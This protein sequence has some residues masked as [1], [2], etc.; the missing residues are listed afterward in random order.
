FEQYDCDY[1]VNSI[2]G[3]GAMLVEYDDLLADEPEWRERASHFA[4]KN[5]DSSVVFSQLPL[6][7]V[8][9]LNGVATYQPSCHMANV[10][11]R[12]EEPVKLLQSIPGMT[13]V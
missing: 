3:C 12:I 5:V 6:P 4:E 7:F 8:K 1:M 11:K 9:K 2:G 10:Q 13:Y